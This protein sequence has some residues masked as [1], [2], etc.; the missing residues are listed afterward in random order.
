MVAERFSKELRNLAPFEPVRVDQ[1]PPDQRDDFDLAQ[2]INTF[3]QAKREHAACP[4]GVVVRTARDVS[5]PWI[6]ASFTFRFPKGAKT[7]CQGARAGVN[8]MHGM[9]T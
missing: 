5:M 2:L 1:V 4:C 7:A 6:S 9:R 3:L 8:S